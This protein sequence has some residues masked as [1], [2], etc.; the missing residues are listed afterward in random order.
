MSDTSDNTAKHVEEKMR[1][2][3]ARNERIA[4]KERWSY[5]VLAVI[6]VLLFVGLGIFVVNY[7]NTNN[8]AWCEIIRASLPQS[9]PVRP[10]DPN[11]QG[12]DQ[13]K[14]RYDDY[15]IVLRLGHRF[16]CL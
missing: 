9:A 6:I 8:K 3:I 10:M 15:E 13:A 7:V 11:A 2:K 5:V 14:K 12:Y 16:G 4:I 1:A